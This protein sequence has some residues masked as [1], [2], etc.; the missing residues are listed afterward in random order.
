MNMLESMTRGWREPDPVFPQE[1]WLGTHQSCV[2]SDFIDR[3]HCEK[4]GLTRIPPGP[5]DSPHEP[6]HCLLLPPYAMWGP[7]YRGEGGK[8]GCGK[9][10]QGRENK[11]KIWESLR[12]REGNR[13][14]E[15]AEL[16]SG[17]VVGSKVL[18]S[19]ARLVV[20]NT[21]NDL[22]HE[23]QTCVWDETLVSPKYLSKSCVNQPQISVELREKCLM[24]H[25]Q[26]CSGECDVFSEQPAWS[27]QWGR[28]EGINTS[29]KM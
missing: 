21:P 29:H 5:R 8:G 9:G 13:E 14:A 15:R 16:L 24:T 10:R 20:P 28:L 22:D 1:P 6:P 7:K 27:R 11:A 19:H 26:K 23:H 17:E 2:C 12:R 4:W 18:H 3:T 25:L